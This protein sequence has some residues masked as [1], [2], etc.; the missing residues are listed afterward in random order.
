VFISS[1]LKEYILSMLRVAILIFILNVFAGGVLFAQNNASVYMLN[2]EVYRGEI[3]ALGSEFMLI[4]Y[5]DQI[6]SLDR[7]KVR[8]VFGPEKKLKV[9]EKEG[10]FA[11]K[12]FDKKW[13]AEFSGAVTTFTPFNLSLSFTEWFKVADRWSVG[14]GV[15]LDFFE[16]AMVKYNLHVRRFRPHN[17]RVKGF[18][19][20]Q[21]GMSAGATSFIQTNFIIDDV[22]VS[23]VFQSSLGA[24]VFYNTG[25]GLALTGEMG[26]SLYRYNLK[27]SFFN[28]SSNVTSTSQVLNVGIYAQGGFMF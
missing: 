2:G 3:I 27:E 8:Y 21:A 13:S 26:F 4:K 25:I 12:P 10:L 1:F 17:D 18:I 15:S 28:G 22:E 16:Y 24:G 6:F 5:D 9:A 11:F 19:D 7:N 20:A 14:A 23:P